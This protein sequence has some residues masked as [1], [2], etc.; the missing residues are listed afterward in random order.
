MVYWGWFSGRDGL[1][2][3]DITLPYGAPNRSWV[4]WAGGSPDYIVGAC[5]GAGAMFGQAVSKY[6][7]DYFTAGTNLGIYRRHGN[8]NPPIPYKGRI[9]FHALNTVFAL[10]ATR[11]SRQSTSLSVGNAEPAAVAITRDDVV[12]EL[13]FEVEQIGAAGH[14]RPGYYHGTNATHQLGSLANS[15]M[16]DYFHNPAETFVTLIDAL[17]Y[18]PATLQQQVRAYLQ[19][20]WAAYSDKVHIG[21]R[22]GAT[23]ESNDIPP[24]IQTRMDGIGPLDTIYGSTWDYR[25]SLYGRWRYVKE[26]G[27]TA[28]AGQ[29][30]AQI[31]NTAPIRPPEQDSDV[32]GIYNPYIKNAYI[33]GYIGYVAIGRMVGIPEAE[34]APY[35]AELDRLLAERAAEFSTDQPAPVAEANTVTIARNFMYMTPDL[36]AYLRVHSLAKVQAALNEYYRVAPYWFVS[37]YNATSNE[38]VLQPLY[39][40]ASLFQAKAYIVR[41]PFRELV[42]WL[43][44]PAFDRGDLFYIQ[45][46][47][48]AL[49][50]DSASGLE[51]TGVPSAA[52]Q[53]ES[54]AFALGFYGYTGTLTVTNTLPLGFSAPEFLASEGT[55]VSPT[56]ESGSRQITWRFTDLAE[57]EIML[58]YRVTVTTDQSAALNNRAEL[59]EPDGDSSTAS[60]IVIANPR[61]AFLP[62][63]MR[64]W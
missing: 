4:Y 7:F 13:T 10:S 44:T 64:N 36:A 5:P 32:G 40:Y 33:A 18:L 24:E 49:K 19:A 62:L 30:F 14:L 3:Y 57:E 1:G 31:R 59:I 55:T 25:Y 41:E 15:Y 45:N 9:Y 6:P 8:Q 42:K 34:L 50:A 22:D 38:G 16:I 52:S 17:P 61:R 51:M 39:D 20:E 63:I 60:F 28:L 23:R 56:Y 54:L 21:W 2:A 12:Q 53:G 26:F 58:S 46:L 43:D 48:A 35:S 11:A 37:K 27:D 29:V 47:I